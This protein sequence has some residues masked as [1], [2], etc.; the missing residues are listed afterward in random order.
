MVVVL[1]QAP[2]GR[3]FLRASHLTFEKTVFRTG[4]GLQGQSAIGPELLLGSET[5]RGL[6][7][8]T[9]SAARIG[10]RHGICRSLAVIACLRLSANSPPRLLPQVLQHV[11]FLIESFGATPHPGF[12]D[13]C[14][15]L[16]SMPGVI[17]VSP[18][19]GNRPAAVTAFADSSPATGL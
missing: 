1:V 7:Q 18:G 13:S 10:P 2:N 8:A 4:A 19:T 12:A 9:A 15:P 14:Q 5:M 17:N 6:D 11:Q 3:Q 16:S